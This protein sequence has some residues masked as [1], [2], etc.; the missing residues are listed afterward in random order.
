MKKSFNT[1][2]VA[3]PWQQQYMPCVA[4]CALAAY[5]KKEGYV[6]DTLHACRMLHTKMY[7]GPEDSLGASEGETIGASLLFPE[8]SERILK[9]IKRQYYGVSVLRKSAFKAYQEIFEQ[10]DWYKYGLVGFSVTH[11]RLYF[12]LLLAKWIKQLCGKDIHIVFGGLRT[13]GEPGTILLKRFNQIDSIINGEG[14]IS[15]GMLI[16][17]VSNGDVSEIKT[18]PGVKV[19]QGRKIISNP[20]VQ[21]RNLDSLPVPYYDEYISAVRNCIKQPRAMIKLAV[22]GS[23]GCYNKCTFCTDILGW[24]GYRIKSPAKVSKELR[25]LAETYD[26]NDFVFVDRVTP[27]MSWWKDLRRHLKIQKKIPPSTLFAEVRPTIT[28]AHLKAM[29]E[30]G[31]T[32]VQ[33]GCETLSQNVLDS[34]RKNSTVIEN[35]RV[36]KIGEELALNMHNNLMIR[37]PTETRRDVDIICEN[38]DYVMGYRPMIGPYNFVLEYGSFVYDHPR[39]FGIAHIKPKDTFC[40]YTAIPAFILRKYSTFTYGFKARKPPKYVKLIHSFKYWCKRYISMRSKG[41]WLLTYEDFGKTGLVEDR[42]YGRKVV[43]LN[44]V[45]NRIVKLC[46]DIC[47]KSDFKMLFRKYGDKVVSDALA[48]L[49]NNK[50]IFIDNGRYLSVPVNKKTLLRSRKIMARYDK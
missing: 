33:V 42:R 34:M 46:E 25:C 5:A 29:I 22:E 45:E 48:V 10:V 17:A 32:K 28:R 2:L 35:I 21:I 1:L 44:E 7:T 39:K 18:I 49:K 23:R 40:I 47:D 38:F 19:R 6:V 13:Y 26:V 20:A 50:I 30:A 11:G 4:I 14:E 36:M 8:N 37:F 9:N 16:D 3:A 43:R 27:H 41:V 31:V 15:F 24:Q 12:S